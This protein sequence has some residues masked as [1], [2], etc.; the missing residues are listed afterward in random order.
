[1]VGGADIFNI[2]RAVLLM[3]VV[4]VIVLLIVCIKKKK[5]NWLL[6]CIYLLTGAAA[7]GVLI[8][9][10]EAPPRSF[11]G[12]NIMFGCAAFVLAAQLLDGKMD[13]IKKNRCCAF[14]FWLPLVSGVI[15]VGEYY[16][17]KSD[18]IAYEEAEQ[19]IYMSRKRRA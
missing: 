7:A 14:Q 13:G 16:A 10:P 19:A 12:A 5:L 11:F 1:M 8:V 9:S 6:P 3:L 2:W 4:L 15:Y 17:L 18:S